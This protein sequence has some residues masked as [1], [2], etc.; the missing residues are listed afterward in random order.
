MTRAVVIG[1]AGFLGSHL[2]DALSAAGHSVAIFDVS[3]SRYA[4]PEQQM[5]VGDVLDAPAVRRAVAGAHVVYNLA[6]IAD[7]DDASTRPI[8]TIRL[9]IEGN[10]NVLEACRVEGVGRFV[11]ASTIYVFSPKGGFYRCSKQ[12][13]E[14][15]VEEF[16]RRHGLDFT[17]LRYGTLY[18]PRADRR[19]S[20]YR[21]LRAALTERRI[22]FAGTGEEMREYVHVRDAARLS[23]EILADAYRNQHVILTGHHPT[24]FKHL[25]EMMCEILGGTVEVVR[26]GDVASPDHYALTPYSFVPRIG[27]KLTTNLYTDL[28]QGL[29]E[30]LS[31]I[32]EEL[33]REATPR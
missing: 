8:D 10:C 2:A 20:I 12:A 26:T 13:A 16:Q 32:N 31:E 29:L 18:G 5:I 7:L 9:N 28:G 14:S 17:I 1:G 25:L 23:V 30:C 22:A 33:A 19:N 6:G 11:Y 27:Q 15:Y 21:Y 3:P 24:K 4:R